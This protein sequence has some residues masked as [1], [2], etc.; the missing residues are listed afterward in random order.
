MISLSIIV[1]FHDVEK[2]LARCLESLLNQDISPEEYEIILINDGSSDASLQIA[3][4]FVRLYQ[5]IKLF[6][7]NNIGVG[8]ARNMGIREASGEY[9]LFVDS[10]D[11]IQQRSLNNIL[12]IIKHQN[13]DLLRFNFEYVLES[14]KI[15]PK[16]NNF[17]H[18]IKFD[19]KIVDGETFLVEHLG[20]A[21]YAWQFLLKTAFIKSNQLFFN[22]TIYFEDIDWLV[23]TLVK[24][25]RVIS[26]NQQVYCYFHRSGS[27]T[28]SISLVKKNKILNDKIFVLIALKTL[29]QES[30]NKK[31]SQWCKGMIS[32]TFMGMLTY[33]TNELP[34]RKKEIIS[35]IKEEYYPL[36]SYRFTSKQWV[37]LVLIN[38]NPVLYCYLKKKK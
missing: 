27:I 24:A 30:L 9:I 23:K 38:L 5:N 8:A 18:S 17:T 4:S 1:P 36:K 25:N 7:Q 11:Y 28:Q 33:A 10:D 26:V 31:V 32:L 15:I 21:C 35:F 2:Y 29:S 12:G 37:N 14:G 19:D 6:S 20:W 13:L 22:E 16:R 3:E 34:E